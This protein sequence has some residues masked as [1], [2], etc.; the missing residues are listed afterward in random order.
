MLQRRYQKE[1]NKL[2]L[3]KQLKP[4]F[5]FLQKMRIFESNLYEWIMKLHE[6]DFDAMAKLIGNI[7]TLESQGLI[8]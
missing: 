4:N 5:E 2:N 6:Q 7:Q 8:S 1:E 3:N